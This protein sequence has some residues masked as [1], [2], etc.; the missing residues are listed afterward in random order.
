MLSMCVMA[1][2]TVAAADT[3][4]VSA[5]GSGDYETTH[6]AVCAASERDV[7]ALGNGVFR[8]LGNRDLDCPARV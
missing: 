5:D 2:A 7:V 6:A 1:A 8:G 4:L 3:L